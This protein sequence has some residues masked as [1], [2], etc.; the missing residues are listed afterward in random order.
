MSTSSLFRK[1]FAPKKAP[2]RE[3]TTISP[4]QLDAS[5]RSRE[6]LLDYTYAHMKIGSNY[7]TF[8]PETGDWYN[9]SVGE[10]HGN[11]SKAKVMTSLSKDAQKI[12]KENLQLQEENNLLKV[13]NEILLDMVAEICSEYSLENKNNKR[14]N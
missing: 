12:Q 14:N 2:Q 7:F 11:K 5:E 4:L 10:Q 9:E 8:D 6:F 13:K 3:A 1:P